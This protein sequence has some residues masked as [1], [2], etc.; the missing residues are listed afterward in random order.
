MRGI[1]GKASQVLVWLGE[2]DEDSDAAISLVLEMNEHLDDSSW[3]EDKIQNPASW[4]EFKALAILF[5]RDYWDRIW[6]VQ[7]CWFSLASTIAQ[8]YLKLHFFV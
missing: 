2:S 1:Y 4:E 6:V 5:T 3:L 8:N 7:V